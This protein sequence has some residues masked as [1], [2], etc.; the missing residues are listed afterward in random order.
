MAL[1]HVTYAVS[2]ALVPWWG[3]TEKQTKVSQTIDTNENTV[4][5]VKYLLQF[6]LNSEWITKN[7]ILLQQN[8]FYFLKQTNV[9]NTFF[10]TNMEMLYF[11]TSCDMVALFPLPMDLF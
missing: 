2:S 5:L 11:S 8:H 9:E 6:S 1:I 10:S 4:A 3:F 7:A